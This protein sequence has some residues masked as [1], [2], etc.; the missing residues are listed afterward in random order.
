VRI[1]TWPTQQLSPLRV[2]LGLVI[3]YLVAVL[4][5]LPLG[6]RMMAMFDIVGPPP[7]YHWVKP[8]AAFA[9]NNVPPKPNDTDITMTPNG[10]Q[11]SGAQSED[12]QLVLNLAPNAAPP[13]PPDIALRI[14]IE[15][16][17]PATPGPALVRHL[18]VLA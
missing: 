9:S 15:P 18:R 3:V 7:P 1:T 8:P 16:L 13:H 11:Q 14:H 17:D 12:N 4:V 6:H 5:V 2:G 10:S